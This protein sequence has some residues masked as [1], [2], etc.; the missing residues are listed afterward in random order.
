MTTIVASSTQ[1][2][3]RD[4]LSFIWRAAAG[5]SI[6]PLGVAIYQ[7][8]LHGGPL[9][10][11]LVPLLA[12]PLGITVGALLMLISSRRKR[13]IGVLLRASVGAATLGIPVAF[14]A[15]IYLF[16]TN[17]G[18]YPSLAESAMWDGFKLALWFAVIGLFAGLCCPRHTEPL[19]ELRSYEN[20]ES[21]CD[22]VPPKHC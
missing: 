4:I 5:A 2:S 17:Y 8:S 10:L 1:V 20:V 15:A 22:W 16:S 19:D 18:D 21:F 14:Y 6:L 13:G 7:V 11:P 9:L 12:A 3:S